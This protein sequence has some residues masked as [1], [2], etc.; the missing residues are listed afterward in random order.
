MFKF[1]H[2][3]LILVGPSFNLKVL[4]SEILIKVKSAKL[5]HYE[6]SGTS[7]GGIVSKLDKQIYTKEIGS[8]WVPRLSKTLVNFFLYQIIPGL[9]GWCNG[10]QASIS[11]PT[12]MSSILSGCLIYMTLCHI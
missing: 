9:L 8:H 2:V 12:P 3:I 10:W 7:G 4:G 11:K 6:P 5:L 1:Y